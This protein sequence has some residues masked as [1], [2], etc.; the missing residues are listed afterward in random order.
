MGCCV[1]C[2]HVQKGGPVTP[3]TNS[4]AH[5]S[6]GACL[7]QATDITTG[8]GY[9]GGSPGMGSSVLLSRT[10]S[11]WANR[12]GILLLVLRP[13][14]WADLI[15]PHDQNLQGRVLHPE[16]HRVVSVKECARSQGF[17]DTFRFFGNIL[18]KH[19]QVC[20]CFLMMWW[21]TCPAV[22]SSPAPWLLYR[23][24][25]QCPLPWRRQLGWRSRSVLKRK[26][27]QK[28]THVKNYQIGFCK[29][30]YT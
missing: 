23:W 9:M 10:L 21:I 14:A 18:D 7:T 15:F 1:G 6:H 13:S 26:P 24:V 11:Q 3:Q 17:P 30:V 12:F 19:R 20:L 16:Q 5:L 8:R 27:N 29:K 22:S 4:L 28:L 2:A 25:M